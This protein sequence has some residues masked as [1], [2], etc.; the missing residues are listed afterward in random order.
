M[1][2]RK[3]LVCW[4]EASE[5]CRSSNIVGMDG[6]WFNL[7]LANLLK[8]QECQPHDWSAWRPTWDFLSLDHAPVHFGVQTCSCRLSVIVLRK[9][10]AQYAFVFA[11]ALSTIVDRQRLALVKNVAALCFVLVGVILQSLSM[12]L[13]VSKVSVSWEWRECCANVDRIQISLIR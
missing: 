7:V 2:T 3:L 9:A 4:I 11:M 13:I 5:C 12:V 8:F 6:V 1:E 10:C